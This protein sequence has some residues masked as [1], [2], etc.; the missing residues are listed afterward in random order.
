L[1]A[2]DRQAEQRHHSVRLDL[3]QALRHSPRLSRRETLIQDKETL[4]PILVDP[5]IGER[6]PGA[7]ADLRADNRA[8]RKI[9]ADRGGVAI[10]AAVEARDDH[11]RR[12]NRAP[13][14][15]REPTVG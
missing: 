15:R 5:E 6:I 2:G 11:M 9:A 8:A 12:S 14:D 4:V 7:V 10:V 3:E 13:R 1:L